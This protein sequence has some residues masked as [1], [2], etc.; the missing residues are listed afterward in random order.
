ME[1][2]ILHWIIAIQICRNRNIRGSLRRIDLPF[3]MLPLPQKPSCQISEASQEK[4]PSN[5][6]FN[7]EAAGSPKNQVILETLPVQETPLDNYENHNNQHP[8][9]IFE[10]KAC[11]ELKSSTLLM[12]NKLI[13]DFDKKFGLPSFKTRHNKKWIE[14]E[15]NLTDKDSCLQM[16]KKLLSMMKKHTC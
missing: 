15:L 7:S 9:E 10:R 13:Q 16:S 3:Y 1:E 6:N 8:V 4:E 11:Q 14:E 12:I 2:D 5:K